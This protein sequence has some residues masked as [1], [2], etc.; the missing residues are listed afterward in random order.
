MKSRQQASRAA[1]DLIE[2]FEGYR[3]AAARLEDGRWTIGYGHTRTARQGA[4]VSEADAEALL[5]YD[6]MEVA[7]ALKDWVYTPLT[8][9]QFDALCAL[10]FNIGL[11]NFRHSNVLRRL[12]EGALL[13]AACA[14]EMWRRVDFE[15][16]PIV[17]DAL[18]RRRAA[19]KALF[20]TPPQ[21]FLPAPSQVLRPLIDRDITGHV[22]ASRPV[23]I[24]APMD[25]ET[26]TAERIGPAPGP[27]PVHQDPPYATQVA[28]DAITA[29]LQSILSED[30][31]KT[32]A[33]RPAPAPEP[34]PE[35]EPVSHLGMMAS[36]DEPP[37]VV[38]AP[39]V[40]EL[41]L[42]QPP[43]PEAWTLQPEPEPMDVPAPEPAVQQPMWPEPSIAERAEPEPRLFS[44]DPMTFEDFESRRVAHHEYQ[45]YPDL[46]S[47]PTESIKGLNP[48]TIW[49]AA[50][51]I[52]LVVFAGGI[53]FGFSARNSG[54]GGVI[55]WGLGIVGIMLVAG[56]VYFLLE[57]L[58][59]RE[60]P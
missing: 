53:F 44:P 16:E 59:G 5:I 15:G 28:A 49:L 46:D 4:E 17:L 8:Q 1:L 29:R 45:T 55:G 43:E 30:A 10:V 22:P 26:A 32:A 57:R 20:L 34:E 21:G 35:P 7:G 2:R 33:V 23:E 54:V 31:A 18:V 3:R 52:G 50:G 39:P 51:A 36:D 27:Q 42:P 24:A 6:L 60:E 12:N 19:E 58:G 25:G 56:A 14:M 13:Q 9:N 48:I 40:A 38:A 47:T 41:D 37:L 11:E